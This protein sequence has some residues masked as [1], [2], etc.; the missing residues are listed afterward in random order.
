MSHSWL[1]TGGWS[2]LATVCA[3]L[4]VSTAGQ[5]SDHA[6]VLTNKLGYF[7]FAEL[8]SHVYRVEISPPKPIR[9]SPE[10]GG[11]SVNERLKPMDHS[12]AEV[13]STLIIDF[14]NKTPL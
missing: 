7:D 12:N 11:G 1:R 13:L 3:A 4:L 6:H 2:W 14:P 5:P 10:T 8:E 9:D